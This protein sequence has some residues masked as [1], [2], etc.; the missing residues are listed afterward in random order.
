MR[1]ALSAKKLPALALGLVFAC[2]LS[3]F[4]PNL[5]RAESPYVQGLELYRQGKY[6]EAARV[7]RTALPEPPPVGA[8]QPG[9]APAAPPEASPAD[10]SPEAAHTRAVLGFTLLRLNQLPEAE[11]QFTLLRQSPVL[12]PVAL[13]GSGWAA[14]ARGRTSAAVDHFAEALAQN[15]GP[16]SGLPDMLR[17]SVPA[18]ARLGQGLIA[19]GRNRATEAVKLLEAAAAGTDLLSSP[20]ELYLALGDARALAGDTPGAQA[21]WAEVPRRSSRFPGD[22][23]RDELARLKTARLLETK[24]AAPQALSLFSSLSGGQYYQAEALSGQA[25]VLLALNRASE[26]LS[27]LR[28]LVPL[29]PAKAEPFSRTIAADPQLRPLYKDWGLAHFHRADYMEAL[30]KF[31]AYLDDVDPKDY[32]SLMGMGWAHLRLGHG[33]QAREAF[34]EAA[35]VR[36]AD[37]SNAEPL[38]GVGAAVLSLGRVA[39]ARGILAKAL[40]AEPNNAVALNTM[41]H[42]E[43]SEGNPGKA[44]EH[45]RAALKARPDYVDSRMAAAKILFDRAEYDAAAAE[46]F[47]LATQEKRSVAALNGLGWARLRL[48]QLNEALA[49]FGEARRLGPSLPEA[50]YGLGMTLAKQGQHDKASQRL[51]EAIFQNPDFAATPEV[52]ELMRSRPEYGELFLEMGEAFARKL[53]P[54]KAAPFLEEYLRQ[55]PN[56]RPGRRAL[57]WASLWAGQEDKAHAL[58][59]TLITVNKGD[60]DAQMGD[61]LAL[62]SR[63]HL[64]RAEPFLRE[65][66]RLDSTNPLTWR[67]LVLLL[68]RQGKQ[69]EAAATQASA[70]KSRLERLD[71]MSSSGFAALHEGRLRDAMRDFRRAVTLDPGLAA[72]RYGLAFALVALG[73]PRQAREELLTGLNLDPAFLDDQELGRLLSRH[74][75]LGALAGDL[76]WSQYYAL[77]LAP[78]RAGFERI[79]ATSP[80]D[81]EALFGLGATAYLQGDWTLAESCFDKLMPRAPQTAPSWDKWSHLMDKLGWTAYHLK[82][83]DKA[84]HAFDWLRTYHPET[85]YAA[86]LSG[87]GWALFAKGKPGPAQDLFTRSLTIFPRNLT[88]MLGMTALKKAPETDE[89][90]MDDEPEPLPVKKKLKKSKRAVD[91]DPASA[92]TSKKS[93]KA[94]PKAKTQKT[95]TPKA[96]VKR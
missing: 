1:A 47:R 70:P 66:V 21:A 4:A 95:P 91:D 19:L 36:G 14:F 75:E 83:Y 64:D 38:A 13:L 56:S 23:P 65:A 57:A 93:A 6:A 92:K 54:T 46:Y 68:S 73:N 90:D 82:K 62:L 55:N 60:A 61:G 37:V 86:P 34:N 7:L 87:M 30:A 33:Q 63:G 51:A 32:A 44:L 84:L 96:K 12:Q 28:R 11:E 48:G 24:G 20:K 42:L 72:P 9:L 58:F 29:E 50:A 76:A 10:L 25:R 69:Q 74:Y 94:A 53:Y 26:A 22:A 67:A 8:P 89:E 40:A 81:L 71:R 80:G 77:N 49:A 79:L 39:E 27:V 85:P 16:A 43:L 18:D 17:E 41:G 45:F 5:A 35:G 31:S 3:L 78:A 15:G 59:Q 2:C 52:L 88:A